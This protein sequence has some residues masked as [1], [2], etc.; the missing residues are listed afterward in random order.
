MLFLIGKK[1]D[2]KIH[3]QNSHFFEFFIKKLENKKIIIS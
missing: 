2:K 1:E 3:S